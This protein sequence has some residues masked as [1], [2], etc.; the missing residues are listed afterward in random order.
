MNNM[1]NKQN[2]TKEA[3]FINPNSAHFKDFKIQDHKI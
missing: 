2:S 3:Q 1:G